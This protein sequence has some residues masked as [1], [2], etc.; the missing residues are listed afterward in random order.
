MR[1]YKN[2]RIAKYKMK[3]VE[4][5]ISIPIYEYQKVVEEDID[6]CWREDVDEDF[7]KLKLEGNKQNFKHTCV[8]NYRKP[9]ENADFQATFVP[10]TDDILIRIMNDYENAIKKLKDIAKR[11]NA[12]L[13][14]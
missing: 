11:L 6:L 1:G 8:Y 14:E 3:G 2:V 13:Y 12:S 7:K 10:F 4:S 9:P 5:I